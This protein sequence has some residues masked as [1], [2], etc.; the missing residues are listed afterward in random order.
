MG[1]RCAVGNEVMRDLFQLCGWEEG[2]FELGLEGWESVGHKKKASGL[3]KP[4]VHKL[5]IVWTKVM[6][7]P[8]RIAPQKRK[9]CLIFKSCRFPHVMGFS[10]HCFIL[11]NHISLKWPKSRLVSMPADTPSSDLGIL[12]SGVTSQWQLLRFVFNA[13][14]RN[15]ATQHCGYTAKVTNIRKSTNM[16]KKKQ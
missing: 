11:K 7:F 10:F 14:F 12:P 15:H 4:T 9:R 6:D 2:T 8:P 16:W 5:L 3:I 1:K 13:P